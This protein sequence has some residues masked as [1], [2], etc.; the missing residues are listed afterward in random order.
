MLK[1]W[2]IHTSSPNSSVMAGHEGRNSDDEKELL[3]TSLDPVESARC[4]F[5]PGKY[6]TNLQEA[7]FLS[8]QQLEG[9]QSTWKAT[10]AASLCLCLDNLCMSLY[11]CAQTSESRLKCHR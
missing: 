3:S 4:V 5:G 11:A 6:N 2:A 7:C 10:K 1:H 9:S 8:E